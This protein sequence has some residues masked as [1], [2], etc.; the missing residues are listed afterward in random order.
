ML[1]RRFARHLSLGT[2][3]AVRQSCG[4]SNNWV[5]L[6]NATNILREERNRRQ[7]KRT[8]KFLG[9]YACWGVNAKVRR[10][11]SRAVKNNTLVAP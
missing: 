7:L 10:E 5:L 6:W 2:L 8:R 4:F 9:M 1:S 3:D 11:L